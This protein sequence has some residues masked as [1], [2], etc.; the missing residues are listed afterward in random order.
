MS[1]QTHQSDP[2]ILN[3]RTLRQDHRR[4]AELLR[5]GMSVLDVGCGTGA[6][7]AGIARQ[8]G[9]V[10]GI[11]RDQSLLDIAR[12]EYASLPNLTF[13]HA[14]ALQMGFHQEF[15]IVSA[16]RVLQWIDDPALALAT[17]ARACRPGGRVVVLDYDHADH[18]WDPAPPTEFAVFWRAF[19]NWRS[20]HRWSNRMASCLAALFSEVG[21]TDICVHQQD[22]IA[23]PPDPGF[24]HASGIWAHVVEVLSPQMVAEGHLPAELAVPAAEAWRSYV[25][26]TLQRQTLVLK[27]V[28]GRLA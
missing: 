17:M 16:A 9:T 19:L 18:H 26:N 22:E 4:L 28:E 20:A 21:L 15:D 8:A 3:R 1:E 25:V 24:S 7:T 11:D 6:I 27:T 2:G 10:V 23:V 12:T 14:D 5:P 13:E